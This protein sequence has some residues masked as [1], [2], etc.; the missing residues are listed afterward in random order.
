MR[1]RSSHRAVMAL[2]TALTACAPRGSAVADS[3]AGDSTRAT[4]TKPATAASA[5]ADTTPNIASAQRPP[6]DK[7]V[8]SAGHATSAGGARITGGPQRPPAEPRS[9]G[10]GGIFV[11][12]T[13]TASALEGTTLER[14]AAD[15]LAPVRDAVGAPSLSPA[16]RAFRVQL[17]DAAAADRAVAQLRASPQVAEAARDGC[18]RMI[19]RP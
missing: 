19:G 18:T 12:V 4:A 14:A 13:V 10:C 15:L 2:V 7:V 3:A 16:I 5:E 9:S 17:R 8:P 11:N 6:T 1:G